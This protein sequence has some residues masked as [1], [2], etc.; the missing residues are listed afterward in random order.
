M[1]PKL[2]KLLNQI[3]AKKIEVQDLVD[4]DKI[5]EAKTAKAELQKLQDK[6]DLLKEVED[7]E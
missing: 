7:S 4:Q 3:N 5:E 1:N 2:R 6:F